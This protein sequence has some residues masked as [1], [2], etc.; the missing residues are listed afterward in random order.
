MVSRRVNLLLHLAASRVKYQV[1]NP[2]EC[3]VDSQLESRLLYPVM[4]LV[5][6][7]VIYQ[8]GSLVGSLVDSRVV[9]RVIS[10]LDCQLGSRVVGHQVNLP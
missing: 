2:V 3:R 4:N 1:D 5:P 9:R 8:A 10:Q 7:P 6:T